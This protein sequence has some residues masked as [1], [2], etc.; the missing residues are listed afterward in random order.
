VKR[1]YAKVSRRRL[2]EPEAFKGEGRGG[3]V[4]LTEWWEAH[5]GRVFAIP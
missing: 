2:Y 5:Q 3:G 4:N 1:G